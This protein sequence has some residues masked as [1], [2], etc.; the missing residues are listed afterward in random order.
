MCLSIFAPTYR[1]LILFIFFALLPLSGL[2]NPLPPL[3]LFLTIP[4][5]LISGYTAAM[6]AQVVYSYVLACIYAAA[7][8]NLEANLRKNYPH[9]NDIVKR[10]KAGK[11]TRKPAASAVKEPAAMPKRRKKR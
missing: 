2:L 6:I 10:K 5:V 11:K 3:Q 8:V 7:Y 1:R 9:M 4:Y